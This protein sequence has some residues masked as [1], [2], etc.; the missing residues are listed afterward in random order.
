M[1]EFYNEERQKNDS[2]KKKVFCNECKYMWFN[3]LYS[4]R[5]C[6]NINNLTNADYLSRHGDESELSLEKQ[7]KNNDCN[8]HEARLN[9][10]SKE[11]KKEK[12]WLKRWWNNVGTLGSG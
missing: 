5:G 3:V 9:S 6:S 1:I 11:I 10:V 12:S 8:L 2:E 4:K 7:N